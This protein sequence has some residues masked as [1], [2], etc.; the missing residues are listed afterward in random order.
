MQI[1]PCHPLSSKLWKS[2]RIMKRM[3]ILRLTFP[4]NL[5]GGSQVKPRDAICPFW[6]W[7]LF[8]LDL[9][10]E[11]DMPASMAFRANIARIGHM[12]L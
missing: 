2:K 4:T 1:V 9:T 5:A 11:N 12:C 8:C 6:Q 3:F 7:R 10:F